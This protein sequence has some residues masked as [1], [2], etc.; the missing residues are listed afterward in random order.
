MF[1]DDRKQTSLSK[2]T[3]TK[4]MKC[5]NLF[6]WICPHVWNVFSHFVFVIPAGSCCDGGGSLC[7][8][9]CVLSS[10]VNDIHVELMLTWVLKADRISCDECLTYADFRVTLKS[11]MMMM[12]ISPLFLMQLCS[13]SLSS[14][15]QPFP[16]L[17]ATHVYRQY[18][19]GRGDAGWR[20]IRAHDKKG[21]GAQK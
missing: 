3:N 8:P 6:K 19:Y 2:T 17:A 10:S 21:T 15:C 12:M 9:P 18:N 13:P 16:A 14:C 11:G 4:L 5:F 7:S 20:S 1:G